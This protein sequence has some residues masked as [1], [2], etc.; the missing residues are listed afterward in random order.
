MPDLLNCEL[1]HHH[2]LH[3][4]LTDVDHLQQQNFH[5]GAQRHPKEVDWRQ[6]GREEKK[7]VHFFFA[8]NLRKYFPT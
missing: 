8:K 4:I 3:E 6:D 5:P 2:R 1:R 7:S